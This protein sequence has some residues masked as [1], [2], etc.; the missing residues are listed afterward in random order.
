MRWMVVFIVLIYVGRWMGLV[1]WRLGVGVLCSVFEWLVGWRL[2]S[3]ALVDG[4]YVGLTV[5]GGLTWSYGRGLSGWLSLLAVGFAGWVFSYWCLTAGRCFLPLPGVS[6]SGMVGLLDGWN[7]WR[8][9]FQL[10]CG[11]WF[12][13]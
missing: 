4:V 8:V 9:W 3:A 5:P 1:G 10:V 7:P 11:F 12:Q 2:L 13:L 6:C